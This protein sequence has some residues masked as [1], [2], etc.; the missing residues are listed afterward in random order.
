MLPNIVLTVPAGASSVKFGIT[1]IDDTET[2]EDELI[3]FALAS[4]SNKLA[5]GTA[6]VVFNFTIERNDILT[7][8]A[9]A[10]KGQFKVY[11]N[12]ATNYV[13]LTLPE[14]VTNLNNI[15]LSVWSLDGRKVFDTTGNLESAKQNLSNKVGN[16]ANGVYIIKVQAGREVYQTRLLKK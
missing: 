5:I 8:I 15:N 11:P 14:K 4:V 10:T 3:S 13:N 9:D 16:L 2:E 12:P 1:V 7:G 6:N